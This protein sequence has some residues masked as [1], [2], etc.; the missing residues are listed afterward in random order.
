MIRPGSQH[1]ERPNADTLMRLFRRCVVTNLRPEH[2]PCWIWGGYTDRKGYP[3]IRYGNRMWWAHRLSYLAFNGPL[4]AGSHIHHTCC[5]PSCVNPDHLEQ[6]S[7]S[8]NVAE[9]NR[10]RAQKVEPPY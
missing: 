2:G 1:S 8:E 9:S 6:T 4:E 10:R 7:P 3:Q 5:E